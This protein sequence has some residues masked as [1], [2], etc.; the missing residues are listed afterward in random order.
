MKTIEEVD[1][2]GRIRLRIVDEEYDQ[3]EDERKA[4]TTSKEIETEDHKN[5]I[6]IMK[7]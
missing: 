7:W 6:T 4:P 3:Y 2:D 1:Q 5:K